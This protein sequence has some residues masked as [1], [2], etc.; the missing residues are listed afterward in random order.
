MDAPKAKDLADRR[1]EEEQQLVV[2][3]RERSKFSFAVSKVMGRGDSLSVLTFPALADRERPT[4][5]CPAQGAKHTRGS[6]ARIL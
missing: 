4:N 5:A 1:P 6:T 3:G 2:C